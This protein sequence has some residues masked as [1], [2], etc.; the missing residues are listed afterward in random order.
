MR[1]IHDEDVLTEGLTALPRLD[2]RWRAVIRACERPP[3]RRREGGFAGLCAI[4]VS[5]Q[6][7][8]A[9]ANAL[10]TKFTARIS[11]LTPEK[12]LAAT[13]EDLRATG[14]SRPKQRSLRALAAALVEGSLALDALHGAS[15]EEV[16]ASLTAVHGIGP[17]T[18]DIYLMACIGHADAFAAGDLALQE[19]ARHAFGL[20]R[21]PSAKELVVLAEAWR[22]WRGIAA[23]VLWSYYRAVKQRE[24][25]TG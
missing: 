18:A 9:S 15:P 17:W 20:E 13:D 19:A 24:G 21:R 25:V 16:H 22:P 1:I 23:R 2:K 7:S 4:I 5:Q 12:M 10:W 8:V 14:L 6:L 3:L 11:P